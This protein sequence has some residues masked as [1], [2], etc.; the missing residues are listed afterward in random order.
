MKKILIIPHHPDFSEIKIRLV[1]IAKALT[2]HYE[3]YLVSWQTASEEYSWQSRLLS[4][5]KNIFPKSKPYK[6]GEINVVEVPIL[7]R[8]LR[9]ACAFNSFWLK[10]IIKR[11]KVDIVINGSFYMFNISPKGKFKYIFDL[12]DLPAGGGSHFSKFVKE[13]LKR[14]FKKVNAVIAASKGLAGYVLEN[15]RKKAF[16][17]PNGAD[18]KKI[19]SVKQENIDEIRKQYNLYGKWIIGYIGY[20][21]EWVNVELVVKAFEEVK[22]YVPRALL[23]WIGASPNMRK[24][25]KLY[26]K[27]D[28]IFAGGV[29]KE[30]IEAY[31]NLL[32]L[33][34]VPTRK[35][36]FQDLAFHIKLIEYSAARKFVIS[37]PLEGTKVM[38]FPNV[39]FASENTEDWVRAIKKAQQMQWRMEWDGLF[40][41]YSWA[42]IAN[43]LTGIIENHESE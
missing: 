5:V 43:T 15:Y 26:E 17:V 11:E 28:V 32:D 34:V 4:A 31:F 20:I 10:N 33:A 8:P 37:T 36:L 18:I 30:N 35:S 3:V 27:D 6:K 13:Q 12:A 9:I 24:L 22:K 14:E 2:K 41:N 21:G 38:N 19:R 39:I 40:E 23:F 42:K 7:H 29:A 16:F 1:E 25:R